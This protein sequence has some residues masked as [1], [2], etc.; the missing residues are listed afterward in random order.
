M[1]KKYSI[2]IT[3]L[4]LLFMIW[5]QPVFAFAFIDT[6]GAVLLKQIISSQSVKHLEQ[7]FISVPEESF[8]DYFKTLVKDN[9]TFKDINV[10]ILPDNNIKFNLITVKDEKL[11]VIGEITKCVVNEAEA[12]MIIHVNKKKL[13]DNKAV[14]FILSN[15]SLGMLAK[16]MGSTSAVYDNYTAKI[17]GND[18]LI[19]F[20]PYV[21][22]SPLMTLNLLGKPL[23]NYISIENVSTEEDKLL[24]KTNLKAD[25]F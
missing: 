1:H 24:L 15:L 12:Q 6:S 5:C 10:E 22:Q 18:I 4:F 8:D 9:N 16:M 14:S 23:V 2:K 11:E 25:I 3:A 13:L 20:K 17:S 19:D 7:G 21:D